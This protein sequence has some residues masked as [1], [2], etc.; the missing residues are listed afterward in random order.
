METKR[1]MERT[2]IKILSTINVRAQI[3]NIRPEER[4]KNKFYNW[5]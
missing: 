2:S 5:L 4:V 3:K 1:K